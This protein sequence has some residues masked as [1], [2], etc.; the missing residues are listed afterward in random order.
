MVGRIIALFV[1]LLMVLFL[2]AAPE[3]AEFTV[4]QLCGPLKSI[5][6]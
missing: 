4:S 6:C 1:F 2:T 5:K 3:I